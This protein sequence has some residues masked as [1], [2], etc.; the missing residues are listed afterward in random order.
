MVCI[1]PSI[2]SQI[3]LYIFIMA[4]LCLISNVCL[5]IPLVRFVSSEFH[6]LSPLIE[7]Q[8]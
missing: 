2:S 7:T 8:F 4:G 5:L 3:M 1:L 6:K